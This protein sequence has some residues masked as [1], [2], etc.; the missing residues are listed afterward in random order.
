MEPVE[1][2]A[3][4]K[5]YY[6]IG[7][8]SWRNLTPNGNLKWSGQYIVVRYYTNN[9]NVAIGTTWVNSNWTLNPDG[10]TLTVGNSYWRRR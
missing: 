10:K 8:T 9:P 2:D 6:Y 4:S 5:G 1:R 7:M 3:I